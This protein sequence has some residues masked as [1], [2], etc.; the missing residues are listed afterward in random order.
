MGSKTKPAGAGELVEAKR[1]FDQWRRNRKGQRRIPDRL[2]RM[3]AKAA[4]I[5]GVPGTA[6]WLGLNPARL[7]QRVDG[8]A[9]DQASPWVGPRFLELPWPGGSAVAECLLEMEGQDGSK[10]RIQLKGEA[11]AQAISLGRMLWKE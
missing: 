3:A 10:L 6:R 11:T 1:G 2:W 4:A 5:H 9:Q 7:K 8:L